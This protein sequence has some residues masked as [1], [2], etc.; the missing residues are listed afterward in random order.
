[1]KKENFLVL[2]LGMAL[3]FSACGS[4]MNQNEPEAAAMEPVETEA[5]GNNFV[6][7]CVLASP[8]GEVPDNL[9]QVDEIVPTDEY[10]PFTKKLVVY[11]LT[12]IG[13]DDISDA[14]MRKVADTIVEM[15]PQ[16][17]TIDAELQ[18]ELLANLYK[19]KAVIPFYLGHD[20]E[21]TPEEQAQWDVTTSQ[22]SVCDIIMED[23]PGQVNE[24][25]EHILHFV[26]DVGLHYTFPE[27]WGISQSSDIYVAMQAAIDQGYYDIAQYG[28]ADSEEM[29]R[30]LIQEYAYWVIF[31]A[32]NLLEPYAPEAEWTG[33]KNRDELREKLP[34]SYE[35][36]ETTI[37]KVM[38]APSIETLEKFK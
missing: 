24:V 1:M 30:V 11:G 19:Y 33:V 12:L 38:A 10:K 8:A 13:R 4:E 18:R 5:A 36:F 6:G 35:V 9:Y 31:T 29:T 3:I 22:N 37:P 15:F 20:H 2:V 26:S 16:N 23:V 7:G 21:M 25:V 28:E 17:E 34:L 27:K 14:F 32:W